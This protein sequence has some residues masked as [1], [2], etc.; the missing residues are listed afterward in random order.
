MNHHKKT[1]TKETARDQLF[2][3]FQAIG[4]IFRDA[5]KKN[6][7]KTSS[8][9]MIRFAKKSIDLKKFRNTLRAS[10]SD[11]KLSLTLEGPILDQEE[12]I[13]VRNLNKLIQQQ[14][15]LTEIEITLKTY[16]GDLFEG[17]ALKNYLRNRPESVTV[18]VND[19]VASAGSVMTMGADIIKMYSHSELMIHNPWTFV[20]GNVQAI[21]KV[22]TDLEKA[23]LSLEE[24]YFSRFS[25]SRDQ[26]KKLLDDETWLTPSQAIQYGL[27]NQEITR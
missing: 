6:E 11:T 3:D 9:R 16:G 2:S 12:C 21:R 19:I 26:L 1:T 15:N 5:N 20:S 7:E 18:I 27:A 14:D 25:Q 22:A 24:A 8:S 13:C 4:K 23:Q 17:I 10:V